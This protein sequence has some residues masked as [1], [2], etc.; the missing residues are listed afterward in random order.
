MSCRH[1]SIGKGERS[2][3]SSCYTLE[4]YSRG[5]ECEVVGNGG[6]LQDR[7]DNSAVQS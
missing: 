7:D 2:K 4:E 5:F 3:M 6:V 1:I